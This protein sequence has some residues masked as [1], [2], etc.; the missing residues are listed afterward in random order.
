MDRKKLVR[1][2]KRVTACIKDFPDGRLVAVKPV[3]IQVPVRFEERRLAV[4][5]AETYIACHFVMIVEDSFYSVCNTNSM[6][7]ITPTTTT[8]VMVDDSEY[9]EFFFDAGSTIAPSL[10]LVMRDVFVYYVYDEFISKGRVPWYFDY[11]DLGKIFETAKEFAGANIGSNQE[12][13]ELIISLIARSPTDRSK[14]YRQF[15]KDL[16]ELQTKPAVFIPLKSV[17]GATNT[18]NKLTGSYMTD[19]IISSL[20]NPSDRVERIE[21]LL[22]K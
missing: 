1:D 6:L 17:Q 21:G 9:Y 14:Y 16:S 2:A 15:V 7:Q 11:E 10:D 12:V 3:K 13:T 18:T 5:G 8:K 20:V 4:I 19:G 22:R